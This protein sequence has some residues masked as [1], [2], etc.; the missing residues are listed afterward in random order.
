ME[1]DVFSRAG[2]VKSKSQDSIMNHHPKPFNAYPV[3]INVKAFRLTYISL[4]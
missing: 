1:G 2:V 4:S 3:M